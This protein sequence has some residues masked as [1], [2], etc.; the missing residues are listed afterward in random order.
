MIFRPRLFRGF[1]MPRFRLGANPRAAEEDG[2]S[3][4]WAKDGR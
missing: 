1:F 4:Q 3:G 2:G